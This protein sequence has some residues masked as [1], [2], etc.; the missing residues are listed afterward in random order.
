MAM[1]GVLFKVFRQQFLK[2]VEI[3]EV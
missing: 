2:I 3:W 1:L